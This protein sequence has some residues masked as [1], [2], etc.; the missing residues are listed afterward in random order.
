MNRVARSCWWCCVE[1]A[2]WRSQKPSSTRHRRLWLLS[3]IKLLFPILISHTHAEAILYIG[4]YAIKKF[5]SSKRGGGVVCELARRAATLVHAANGSAESVIV[6]L[7]VSRLE[8]L[9]GQ[10]GRQKGTRSGGSWCTR[11]P[12]WGAFYVSPL[13][14]ARPDL[15]PEPA[16]AFP[17]CFVQLD[18]VAFKRRRG[19]MGNFSFGK[20]RRS[21]RR[22]ALINYFASKRLFFALTQRLF[23]VCVR[24]FF[25]ANWPVQ[26]CGSTWKLLHA[27]RA[28]L[29]LDTTRLSVLGGSELNKCVCSQIAATVFFSRNYANSGHLCQVW[30]LFPV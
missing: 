17:W 2:R 19:A 7:G 25:F 16:R 8:R 5:A 22:R 21:Q 4:I 18:S 3:L 20:R 30:V 27:R 11:P 23:D 28:R 1:F 12:R 24:A 10:G 26:F 13:S 14:D 15:K 9:I 6:H 29:W